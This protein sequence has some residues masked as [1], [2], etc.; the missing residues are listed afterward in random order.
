[1]IGTFLIYLV[2]YSLPVGLMCV[3]W[4]LN[5]RRWTRL[6]RAYRV[7][8]GTDCVAKRTMQTVILVAGDVGW[9]SYKGIVTVG[10]TREGILLKL[11]PPFSLFHPPILIPYGDSHIEPKRWY[12]IGKTLQYTLR[13]V[14]DVKM[15][16]HDDLQDWIESQV[17]S[18]AI[19]QADTRIDDDVFAGMPTIV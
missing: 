4:K 19:A 3:M 17:A 6:A 11:M 7:V 15:I 9:N 5:A 8:E 18:L 16:V 12:L 1:M 13:E 2:S 14:S 10:V